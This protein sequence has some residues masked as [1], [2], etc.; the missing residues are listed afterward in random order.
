MKNIKIGKSVTSIG[1][2]AFYWSEG[3]ETVYL[4][5]LTPP[6]A[7]ICSFADATYKGILYVPNGSLK[8]YKET[9]PWN[10][11]TNIVEFDFSK[12]G[13]VEELST[14]VIKVTGQGGAIEVSGAEGER[15]EVNS[16]SG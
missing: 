9:Y 12:E 1:K 11:F 14:S 8:V 7:D 5:S 6:V 10:T 2:Y 3:L 13:K 15:V 16:L 4:K